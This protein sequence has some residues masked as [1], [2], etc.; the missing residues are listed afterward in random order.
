VLTPRRCPRGRAWRNLGT[1]H[2]THGTE[3]E[4]LPL[5]GKFK[6]Q[7]RAACGLALLAVG[8][9]LHQVLLAAAGAVLIAW[10]TYRLVMAWRAR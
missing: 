5:F 7:G 9:V 1:V 3:R 2:A 10:G 8:L 4:M 6:E